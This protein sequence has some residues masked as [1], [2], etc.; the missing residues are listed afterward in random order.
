M[1]TLMMR[2]QQL[3]ELLARE[4]ELTPSQRQEVLRQLAAWPSAASP[5]V[6]AASVCSEDD[7]GEECRQRMLVLEPDSPVVSA[8]RRYDYKLVSPG[9]TSGSTCVT[10]HHSLFT[11]LNNQP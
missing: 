7:G 11:I 5:A 9:T 8:D 2:E 6:T 10:C 4:A 1:E 3:Q